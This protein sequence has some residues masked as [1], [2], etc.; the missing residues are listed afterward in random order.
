MPREHAGIVRNRR[1]LRCRRRQLKRAMWSCISDM[2]ARSGSLLKNFALFFLNGLPIVSA[3][4]VCK[5]VLV[6]RAALRLFRVAGRRRIDA[7]QLLQR[8]RPQLFVAR[9]NSAVS[10]I[11]ENASSKLR[12]FIYYN[13]TAES[14]NASQGQVRHSACLFRTIQRLGARF[15]SMH[16]WLIRIRVKI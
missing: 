1:F 4:S 5:N 16:P 3:R 7:R 14:I 2:A 11:H 13:R 10:V 6:L 15:A 8:I 9:E 12:F